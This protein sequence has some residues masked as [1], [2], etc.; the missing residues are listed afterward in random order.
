MVVINLKNKKRRGFTLVEIIVVVILIGILAAILVPRY[1]K[2][3]SKA[4]KN[5]ALSEHRTVIGQVVATYSTIAG[6][7]DASEVF[8]KLGAENIISDG[9]AGNNTTVTKGVHS[10]VVTTTIPS[11]LDAEEQKTGGTDAKGGSADSATQKITYV[12]IK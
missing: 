1:M 12:F 4:K 10:I 5:T 6:N 3:T 2:A 9:K 11:G 8:S 7:P